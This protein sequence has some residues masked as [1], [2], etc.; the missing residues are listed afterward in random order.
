MSNNPHI[1]VKPAELLHPIKRT[2]EDSVETFL[3]ELRSE[4][5]VTCFGCTAKGGGLITTFSLDGVNILADERVGPMYGSTFWTS[6]QSDWEWPPPEEIDNDNYKVEVNEEQPCITLTSQ[7]AKSLDVQVIKRFKPVLDRQ[8]IALEYEIRNSGSTPRRFAPWEISRVLPGGLTFYPTGD[9]NITYGPCEPLPTS[10]QN[11]I[12]WFHHTKEHV[13]G[14]HKLFADGKQGWIAHVSGN[15]IF[16]KTFE[17]TTPDVA[18]P[19]EGEIEIYATPEYEEVEQQGAF[20]EI[21]PGQSTIW[22]VNWYLRKLQE[23]IRIGSGSE[24]LIRFVQSVI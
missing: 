13:T 24:S 8:A 2:N 3:L 1:S 18:A 17:D 21:A 7:V 9:G 22:T 10:T 23:D 5:S 15:L 6:P 4:E 11:G 12:T 16:I 19:G 20:S 14:Q